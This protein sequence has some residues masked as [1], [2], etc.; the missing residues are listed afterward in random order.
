MKKK[1]LSQ[2]HNNVK[3]MQFRDIS[4]YTN[5]KEIAYPHA[6]MS[7]TVPKEVNE[8]ILSA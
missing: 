2:G 6:C 8:T 5:H 7:P 3:K 1:R 4:P